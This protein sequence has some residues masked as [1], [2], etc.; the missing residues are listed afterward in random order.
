[1]SG[2]SPRNLK[3]MRAM[4]AAYPDEQF[5]QQAV[6]QIPWGH[7][8]RILDGVQ[9]AASR[10]FYIWQTIQNGWSRNVLMLQ[11]ESGLHKRQGMAPTNFDRTL[12]APQS[13]LAQQLL[14]DPYNF[15]F[16]M[17]AGDARERELERGLFQRFFAVRENLHASAPLSENKS[18]PAQSPQCGVPSGFTGMMRPAAVI[19]K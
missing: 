7:N 10:E 6:A 17:L 18:R 9:E 4:A 8:V 3:Y 12:P 15:D 19:T 11:I 16:L 14:K 13:D 2:F 5:V 1:M